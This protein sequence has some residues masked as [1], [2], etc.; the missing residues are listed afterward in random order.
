MSGSPDFHLAFVE[1][2][3][4]AAFCCNFRDPMGRYRLHEVGIGLSFAGVIT[5]KGL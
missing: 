2:H 5:E 3:A 4:H 1:S